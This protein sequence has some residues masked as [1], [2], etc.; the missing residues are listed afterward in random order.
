MADVNFFAGNDL[1][2]HAERRSDENYI[3][4][5]LT[6]DNTRFIL[7][8]GMNPVANEIVFANSDSAYELVRAKRSNLLPI[9]HEN[10][11]NSNLGGE[12]LTVEAL[13]EEGNLI[14]LG[15]K[16]TSEAEVHYFALDGSCR[17][18]HLLESEFFSK[19][20]VLRSRADILKLGNT[21]AAFVAQS[22]SML[23]WNKRY[24]FCSTCGSTTISKDAGYKRKCCN[25]KCLSNKG[26]SEIFNLI[27]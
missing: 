27:S 6:H 21:D 5:L 11:E 23:D 25:E 3:R 15:S 4:Q 12:R 14:F 17:E 19:A 26:E 10:D 8:M 1:D 13:L 9:L 7:F 22:R 20:K 24:K 16:P 2:R 18:N